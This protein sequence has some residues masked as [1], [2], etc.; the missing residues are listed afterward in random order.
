MI[1]NKNAIILG[2]YSISFGISCSALSITSSKGI[3]TFL[4]VQEILYGCISFV[5]KLPCDVVCVN[6]A[7]GHLPVKTDAQILYQGME[8][9]YRICFNVFTVHPA[10]LLP[11]LFSINCS[12]NWL[13][14]QV[15]IWKQKS[16]QLNTIQTLY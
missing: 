4:N 8:H 2:I 6:T 9:K 11:R 14:N 12:R 13:R 15:P 5:H 3:C 16:A 1:C 7:E 10:Q